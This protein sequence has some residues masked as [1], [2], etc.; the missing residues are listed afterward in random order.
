MK[1][2]IF[3][4]LF[5]LLL[6]I[7][8]P[9]FLALA[10][11][12]T[13]NQETISPMC[14]TEKECQARGGEVKLNTSEC[15]PIAPY[16]CYPKVPTFCAP[17]VSG[18]CQYQLQF[19]IGNQVIEG[20]GGYILAVFKFLL[21]A[22]Y[23]AAGLVI[24]LNGLRWMLAFGNT[25]AIQQA[26]KGIRDALSGLVLLFLSTLLLYTINPS[27]IKLEPFRVPLMK[28]IP[29]VE[30]TMA[31]GDPCY[32]IKDASKCKAACPDCECQPLQVQPD[33]FIKYA[34]IVSL[35]ISGA[36]LGAGAGIEYPA[37]VKIAGQLTVKTFK[38]LWQVTKYV[39]RVAVANPKEAGVAVGGAILYWESVKASNPGEKGVCVRKP[40]NLKEGEMC[41]P[42][43]KGPQSQC[44][45]GL[46]CLKQ[47]LFGV[48]S[49]GKEGSFCKEN[50]DC[51]GEGLKCVSLPDG[52]G[53][54]VCV[55]PEK[56]KKLVG[57]K[58]GKNEDC[59]S[60]VCAGSSVYGIEKNTCVYFDYLVSRPGNFGSK[61]CGIDDY[62]PQ[63]FKCQSYIAD[64]TYGKEGK[65]CVK[66]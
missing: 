16:F 26:Q 51:K 62:C 58:C 11:A 23:I 22:A 19:K 44:A 49:S 63:G 4:L 5:I 15:P 28:S 33:D 42:D 59:Q 31:E 37:L 66:E 29:Y 40:K 36:A 30:E 64:P 12:Q 41:D 32:T 50:S 57:F 34:R 56:T 24:I 8:S 65:G 3:I 47:S 2:F 20:L 55:N 38:A 39:G 13:T 10:L 21:A 25:S 60:G 9:F 27:L 48:C 1:K 7:I 52:L 45:E 6:E 61:V 17:G 35:A 46:T 43:E 53:L 18:T 54:R 14:F